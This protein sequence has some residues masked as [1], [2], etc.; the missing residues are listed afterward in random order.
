MS[1][2]FWLLGNLSEP[3]L[4]RSKKAV[5]VKGCD[6]ESLKSE[7]AA[8]LCPQ[9]FCQKF[10]L[11]S[12]EFELRHRFE[13]TIDKTV[14]GRQLIGG[15]AK[16]FVAKPSDGPVRAFACVLE[17]TQVAAGRAMTPADLSQLIKQSDWLSSL[18]NIKN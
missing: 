12:R 4:L 17:G 11:D 18:T 1:G 8:R 10:L 15:L 16:P 2:L 14:D 13:V 3:E 9:L 7:N 5:V 6:A